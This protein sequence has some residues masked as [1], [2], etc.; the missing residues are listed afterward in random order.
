[1][2][3]AAI[4]SVFNGLELLAGSI[5]QIINH[6]DHIVICYQTT[7]NRGAKNPKL[8]EELTAIMQEFT[9]KTRITLLNW[10]PRNPDVYTKQNEVEKHNH[11]L[12]YIKKTDATHYIFAATD[13][14][15]K[16]DQFEAAKNT[17]IAKDIDSSATRLHSYYKDPRFKLDYLEGYYCTFINKLYPSSHALPYQSANLYPVR[18]DPA[19]AFTPTLNFHEF[20]ENEIVMHHYTMIRNDI[21]NKFNNAAASVNWQDKISLFIKEYYEC[22]EDTLSKPLTYFSGHSLILVEN[23]F[24]INI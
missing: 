5:K 21:E 16:T 23:Q 18:V 7:S 12:E 19:C 10:E 6:V 17:I 2:K 22:N 1:M 9:P 24:N 4:Y 15:Y 20:L 11:A 8:L 3:L 14:Y 13:H